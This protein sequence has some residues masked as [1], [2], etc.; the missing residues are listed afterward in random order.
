MVVLDL[1]ALGRS[2]MKD[3]T[4]WLLHVSVCRYAL[5]GTSKWLAKLLHVIF[6][7]LIP[8]ASIFHPE[9]L[10]C[11]EKNASENVVC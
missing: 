4:V 7:T 11:Q 2:Q 3:Q 5:R 1:R 9:P 6:I 8:P 10:K